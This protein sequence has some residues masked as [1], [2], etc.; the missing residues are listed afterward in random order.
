MESYKHYQQ[1][2]LNTKSASEWL[3]NKGKIDSQ[4]RKPYVLTKV[5]VSAEFCGQAYAGATNYHKS[6]DAFNT[7]LEVVIRKDFGRLSQMALE[8]LQAIE[9]EALIG[10]EADIA[11]MN[12]EIATAKAAQ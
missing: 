12:D 6:P 11:A 9:R 1:T 7:A 2:K 8:R 10:C 5:S 3:A 4:D